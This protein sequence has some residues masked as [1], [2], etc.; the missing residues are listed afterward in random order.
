MEKV[1][2]VGGAVIGIA[3]F[4]AMFVAAYFCQRRPRQTDPEPIVRDQ[5]DPGDPQAF[6]PR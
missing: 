6:P 2:D 4:L 5:E 1:M 3:V